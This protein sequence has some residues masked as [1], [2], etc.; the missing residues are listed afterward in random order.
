MSLDEL[1]SGLGLWTR[2]RLLQVGAASAVTLS[3]VD[4][5]KAAETSARNSMMEV[6]FEKR[7][8]RVAM[9]G[10]GGRGTSLLG[11]LL[12]A[13]AQVVAICDIVKE[14]A[15]H[16]AGLVTAAGQKAPE[17]YTDGPHHFEAL[18]ARKDIDFVLVATPWNWHYP[19]AIAAM[20]GGKDVAIE[21]PGVTTI[22]ECWN[23]VRTSE[24][25]RKHCM[26]LEN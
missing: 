17:L 6:K 21:V 9:I 3:A 26:M 18:C 5:A 25:T 24:E 23:I 20:K 12:A 19:M 4:L 10:T 13:D 22:E 1:N 2:R 14:K 16:A 15:E 11:L 7:E 8:P